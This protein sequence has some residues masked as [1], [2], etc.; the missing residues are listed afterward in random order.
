MEIKFSEQEIKDLLSKVKIFEPEVGDYHFFTV[1]EQFAY[2]VKLSNGTI[3]FTV[4]ELIAN[5]EQ[6]ISKEQLTH[7]ANCFQKNGPQKRKESV[8]PDEYLLNQTA[9]SS[10]INSRITIFI[11]AGLLILGLT[12]TIVFLLTSKSKTPPPYEEEYIES[13]SSLPNSQ[14]KQQQQQR[15]KTEEE[16]KE[17]IYKL[18]LNNPKKYIN[19]EFSWQES[20]LFDQMKFEGRI[21]NSASM[22]TFQNFNI[23]IQGYSDTDYM[24]EERNYII[25]ETAS[26]TGSTTFKLRTD[27]WDHRINRFE[28]IVNGAEGY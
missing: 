18:E 13:E 19:I 20:L 17:D 21:K 24:L 15:P 6:R 11:V 8:I 12:G 3:Y 16:L 26:A 10:K 22:V 5:R 4:D 28:M 1:N 2:Q 23:T 9:K 27:T 7:I 25:T 14:I